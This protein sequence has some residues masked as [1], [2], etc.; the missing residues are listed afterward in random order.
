M[1]E[2]KWCERKSESKR[3][4][5]YHENRCSKNPNPVKPNPKS[6]NWLKAMNSRKGKGTNHWTKNPNYKMSDAT[7]EKLSK[8]G[9]GRKHSE[10]TKKKIS[11]T[12]K[13][14][15]EDNP[16]NH[17]WRAENKFKS[18]PCEK[19]KKFLKENNIDFVEEYQPLEDRFF[20]IDIAIPEVM[21]AIEVNGEQHYNRDKTLKK[22]YQE[23]HDLIKEQGWVIYEIHYS[24]VYD[25]IFLS[26]LVERIR[27]NNFSNF[28]IDFELRKNKAER[29]RKRQEDSLK[30]KEEKAKKLLEIRLE[31]IRKSEKNWGWVSKASRELGISHTHVRRLVNKYLPDT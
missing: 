27:K 30:L 3:G 24:K 20:S 19:L 26:S 7:R 29:R 11:E 15:L 6:E 17:P 13:K 4:L 16:D 14:Y 25:D 31:H 2:C 18:V 23:R 22:Y 12:R 1:Y 5:K 8:A 28:T 9:K 10:E 21:F